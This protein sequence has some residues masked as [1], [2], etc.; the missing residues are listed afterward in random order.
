MENSLLEII[1]NGEDSYTE[2]KSGRAHIDSLAKEMVA[3]ANTAGGKIYLGIEDNGEITG[4]EK[5]IWEEKLVQIVRNNIEPSL[6]IFIKNRKEDEKTVLQVEIEKGK[7]KPYKVKTSNKYYIR[8]GSVSTEPSQEELVRLFQD[9]ELLHFEVKSIPGTTVQ[10]LESILLREYCN[11][12]RKIDLEDKT[13][14][15][16]RNLQ[17][18]GKNFECTILGMLYFG[19]ELTQFLPQ[20]GI[21]MFRFSGTEKDTDILD[22]KT[23]ILPI[24]QLIEVG[25]RFI[26]YNSSTKAVFNQS[27]TRREDVQEYPEFVVRELLSNAFAHRDWSIFG[28]R[29]KID[30]FSD[31]LEI[32]S[33]GK[34]P[35]T[36]ELESAISGISYYRNPIISQMLKD[37]SLVEKSGRGLLK[38]LNYY[39]KNKLSLPRFQATNFFLK[40]TLYPIR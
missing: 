35:N 38:I 23:E 31:R 6:S 10:D 24:P 4:V 40:V 36:L 8:V 11:Q 17:I 27:E 14:E 21:D 1:N 3:F 37:Y 15:L 25:E 2:F 9:G 33:P 22:H 19:K 18:L 39:K 30:I 5:K 34:L 13:E 32:F 26:K 16:F 7:N 20:S 28:Q 12:H 29:V